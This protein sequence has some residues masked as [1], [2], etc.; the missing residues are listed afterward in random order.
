[1]SGGGEIKMVQAIFFSLSP[2]S[3][4]YRIVRNGRT[5]SFQQSL[6]PMSPSYNLKNS[7]KEERRRAIMLN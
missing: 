6:Q 4:P 7:G 3:R 1:L 2:S 5:T